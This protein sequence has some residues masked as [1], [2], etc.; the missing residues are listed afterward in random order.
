MIPEN[1]LAVDSALR[2]IGVSLLG[3]F[4]FAVLV[5]IAGD[6]L[7]RR[8]QRKAI[9][10]SLNK[11]KWHK[12]IATI[13]VSFSLLTSPVA[14]AQT[15]AKSPD[16]KAAA[17]QKAVTRSVTLLKNV[18]ETCK[19]DECQQLATD[20]LK[21]LADIQSK[22]P[23]SVMTEEEWQ[24]FKAAW[25]AHLMKVIMAI[26]SANASTISS[27]APLQVRPPMGACQAFKT[28]EKADPCAMCD[29]VFAAASAICALYTI[30]NPALA[31]ACEAFA[32]YQYM[33]CI[34]TW[35]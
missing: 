15:E 12:L 1:T 27:L 31:A 17:I 20:G 9:E 14:Y 33:Q 19:T 10:L 26:H 4:L 18:K 25:Q 8:L 3:L 16:S 2:W 22:H 6:A 23:N 7:F 13:L 21:M 28:V 35:C 29:K 30:T 5:I 34:D 24:A 32:I 11:V